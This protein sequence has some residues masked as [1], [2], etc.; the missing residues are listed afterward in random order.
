MKGGFCVSYD[1]DLCQKSD[2]VFFF[3]RKTVKGV[4]LFA[5]GAAWLWNHWSHVMSSLII[6]MTSWKSDLPPARTS[7]RRAWRLL[8]SGSVLEATLGAEFD[9]T[10][11]QNITNPRRTFWHRPP[12]PAQFVRGKGQF[13][14]NK[15]RC[16]G[17]AFAAPA[18]VW[19]CM[20]EGLWV[21]HYDR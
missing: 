9:L 11:S 6:I 20:S 17:R 15:Q 1:F 8:W 7:P 14:P 21:V 2:I 16:L 4:S 13:A 5:H 12:T 18:A 10:K 3:W 19:M